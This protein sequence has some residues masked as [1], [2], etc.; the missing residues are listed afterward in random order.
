MSALRRI[1]QT[2]GLNAPAETDDQADAA[3]DLPD[4]PRARLRELLTS[5]EPAQRVLEEAI[6]AR[7][8]TRQLIADADQAEAVAD[9]LEQAVS[10]A[11]RAWAEAGAAPGVPAVDQALLD[12]RA[13]A[14]RAAEEARFKAQGATAALPR[15]A[16]AE[17]DARLALSS[18]DQAIRAAAADVLIS[19]H[20]PQVRALLEAARS[21]R[22]A[23]GELLPLA[24]LV[25][26]LW[27]ASHRYG[28]F[29]ATGDRLAEVFESARV[30]IPSDDELRHGADKFVDLARADELLRHARALC[31]DPDAE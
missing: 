5:R 7:E 12:R 29:A 18:T 14:R 19:E 31:A 11:T 23:L 10:S 22:E 21:Y 27:G 6:A 20:A 25:R 1:A 17:R 30:H 24:L 16:S 2:L 26:P 4:D 15:L 9:D 28:Q 8:R 13:T 3:R